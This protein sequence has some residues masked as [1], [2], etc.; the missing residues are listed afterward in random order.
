MKIVVAI[1][2]F[3]GSLSSEEAGR[4]VCEGVKKVYP[5]AQ[6]KVRPL[7]DGGEGTVNT[8]VHGMD[9]EKRKV[10]V[11]GPR[12]R[13]IE[14]EYGI[15]HGNQTAVIE[16]ASAAGLPLVEGKDR[17]PLY[18]TTYGVGEMIL[19]AIEKGCRKFI[20][21]IGGSATND[22]GIGMLQALG[23]RFLDEEGRE[24]P[25]GAKGV[26]KVRKICTEHVLPELKECYFR[27]A[28]DVTNTLCGKK[29][30][31]AIY[32]PQKGADD[33]LVLQMDKWMRDYAQLV[34]ETYPN[35]DETYPGVGAAGGLGFA[36]LTFT[37]AVL[38]PGVKIV[39][40]ETNLGQYIKETDLVITGEGRMDGQTAMGKAPIGVAKL[41]KRFGKPVIAFAGGV[42]TDAMNCN[43]NGIDAFFPIV[44]KAVTLQE[45][46]QPQNAKKNMSAAVEQVM[47]LWKSAKR[48]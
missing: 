16:M 15:L 28:C 25:F 48:T 13:M 33:K 39:L 2:S 31:S 29:G 4:A 1:D 46:M 5:N 20:V 30:C 40:E 24:V 22:A 21:G 44:R 6:I 8:L 10:K 14:C 3:K 42:T 19:D 35:A 7:A 45:A 36:F 47:R 26:A 43:E 37:K 34:K 12:G 9:G 32:G 17:N 27:V 23:Y 18:T 38:E 41:A 11:T